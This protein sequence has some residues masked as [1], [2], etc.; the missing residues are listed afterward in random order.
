M[1]RCGLFLLLI[2]S[3]AVAQESKVPRVT[4]T[5]PVNTAGPVLL[6]LAGASSIVAGVIM[7]SQAKDADRCARDP[8]CIGGGTRRA[9]EAK[10][11]AD[12]SNVALAVGSV[13]VAGA[14]VWAIVGP[15]ITGP[16]SNALNFTKKPHDPTLLVPL[17]NPNNVGFAY[18]Q[19]F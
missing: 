1:V 11:K 4:A 19:R 16:S 18:T 8:I 12:A 9:D 14:L 17:L 15:S 2:A 13:A 7:A 5:K 6:T 3:T 10:Q